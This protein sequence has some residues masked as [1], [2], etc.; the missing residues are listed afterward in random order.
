MN[1]PNYDN[2][3]DT[4]TNYKQLYKYMPK[5]NF[6]MLIAGPSGSGKTNTLMHM[7]HEPLIYFDKLFLY[8]KNLEQSKYQDLINKFGEISHQIGYNVMECSNDD[9]IPVVDLD[10]ESQKV[11]IFDDFVCE[12][13]Q[14]PIIDYFIRG[15]HKNCSVIYLSQSY[16][17]TPKDIRL[18]CSHFCVYEFPSTNERGLITRELGVTKEQYDRAVN[19]PYSFLYVDKP[20]KKITRNFYGKI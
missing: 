3:Q 14:R 5:N 8:A 12:K 1:I 16:Y 17:K 7:L 20:D 10:N 6:R 11:V 18:N 15:R 19:K 4:V 13:N 9:I 2:G